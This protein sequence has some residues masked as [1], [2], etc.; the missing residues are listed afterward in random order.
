[1]R[2]VLYT[3][4]HDHPIPHNH[5]HQLKSHSIERELNNTLDDGLALTFPKNQIANFGR[6]QDTN[7]KATCHQNQQ[8]PR[9]SRQAREPREFDKRQHP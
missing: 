5:N 6:D 8:Y 4:S 2:L 1:M 9:G 3:V 7:P